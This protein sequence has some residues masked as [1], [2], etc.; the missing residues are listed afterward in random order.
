VTEANQADAVTAPSNLYDPTFT[1]LNGDKPE[2]PAATMSQHAAK[3]YTKWLSK[4]TGV[5]YR[6]PYEAEW[7]YAC[8]AGTTTAFSFG[9]DPSQLGEYGWFFDNSDGTTHPVGGKKPNPWGLHDMHGNVAEWVLGEY[10]A[11]LYEKFAGKTVSPADVVA[12]P[13]KLFPRVLRGGNLDDDAER[14]RSA[15]RKQS[16]DDDWRDVDPNLPKSPWWFTEPAALGVGM[17]IVRPLAP[18]SADE[19]KH[20]WEVDIDSIRRDEESRLLQGRGARG[21]VDPQLLEAIKKAGG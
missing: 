21:L 12:W 10:S 7:E 4:L 16:Q 9:D 3:Q 18:L 15:A 13:T 14:C 1:F 19:Q 20:V 8:R 6:L 5:M 11:N 2:L 17:R